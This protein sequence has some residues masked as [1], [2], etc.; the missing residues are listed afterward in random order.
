MTTT[1]KYKLCGGTF[2]TLLL[3]AGKPRKSVR[4]HYKGES[5]GLDDPTRPVGL[6]KITIDGFQEPTASMLL[7]PSVV[8]AFK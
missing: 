3:H 8:G 5:E 4:E 7:M 1:G 2:F 6:A